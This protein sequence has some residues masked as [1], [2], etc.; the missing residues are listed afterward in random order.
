M[1]VTSRN[2]FFEQ[3]DPKNIGSKEYIAIKCYDLRLAPI[4]RQLKL[5]IDVGF[6]VTGNLNV[7]EE[8]MVLKNRGIGTDDW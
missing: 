2:R 4:G 3:V 5:I 8:F 1:A 7:L 6:R